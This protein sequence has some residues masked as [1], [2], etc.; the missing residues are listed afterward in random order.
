MERTRYWL[1][2]FLGF[3]AATLLLSMIASAED[4]ATDTEKHSAIRDAQIGR[5][6]EVGYP[7]AAGMTED[8]FKKLVPIPESIDGAVLA[9]SAGLVPVAKQCELLGITDTVGS[10]MWDVNDASDARV[11]WRY[12][13]DD[14]ERTRG[15]SVARARRKFKDDGRVSANIAETLAVHRENPDTTTAFGI[16]APG[17]ACSEGRNPYLWYNDEK[18]RLELGMGLSDRGHPRWGSASFAK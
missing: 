18:K 11:Y 7:A 3:V 6:I 15:M 16:D 14:G 5:L 10:D 9:V 17:S 4:E 13:A 12:G 1:F 2:V 8:E